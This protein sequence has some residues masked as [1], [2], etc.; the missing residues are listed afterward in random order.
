MIVRTR[1]NLDVFVELALGEVSYMTSVLYGDLVDEVGPVGNF[2]G[3]ILLEVPVG[4]GDGRVRTEGFLHEFT[5]LWLLD[6]FV[7]H[8][9]LVDFKSDLLKVLVL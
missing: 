7:T 2:R 6:I 3:L 9:L 4:S 8:D 1:I 5:R